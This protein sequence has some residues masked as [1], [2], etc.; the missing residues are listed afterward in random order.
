M[1]QESVATCHWRFCEE[2]SFFSTMPLRMFSLHDI[3]SNGGTALFDHHAQVV[4]I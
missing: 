2:Q 3:R 4:E 1:R